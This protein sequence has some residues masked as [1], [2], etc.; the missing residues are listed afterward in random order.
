MADPIAVVRKELDE[1]LIKE[2]D[3]RSVKIEILLLIKMC[4]LLRQ[5]RKELK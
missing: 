3:A 4:R 2:L 1:D 5:L